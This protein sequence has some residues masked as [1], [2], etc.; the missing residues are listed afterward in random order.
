MTRIIRLAAV[1]VA[2]S[3]MTASAVAAQAK[4]PA[5]KAPAAAKPAKTV[6]LSKYWRP[7]ARRSRTER[8]NATLKGVSKETEE[9]KTRKVETLV[10]GKSRDLLV[11][12][13][14]KVIEVEEGSR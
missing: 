9:R 8:K 4:A 13:A 7:C 2:L 1:I 12:P 14:G 5:A 10:N 11:D 6:D 3:G